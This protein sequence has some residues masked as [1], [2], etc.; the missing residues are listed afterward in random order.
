MKTTI[1]RDDRMGYTAS[2][3]HIKKKTCWRNIGTYRKNY[4]IQ[5][6]YVL[7]WGMFYICVP[8]L[9]VYVAVTSDVRLLR[10]CSCD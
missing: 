5:D 6:Q 8:Y 4:D 9:Y 10:K 2:L 3:K 1:G 7:A